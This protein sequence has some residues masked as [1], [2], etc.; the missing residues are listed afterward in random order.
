MEI[1]RGR[2][3]QSH[4][5]LRHLEDVVL[6]TDGLVVELGTTQSAGE[7]RALQNLLLLL[8]PAP[9]VGERVQEEMSKTTPQTSTPMAKENNFI[10]IRVPKA[11][12]LL[13]LVPPLP[14]PS[15]W[16]TTKGLL[17]GR[18]RQKTGKKTGPNPSLDRR[19]PIG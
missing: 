4:S 19:R 7:T 3:E 18:W 11:N 16:S 1:V 10:R 5:L 13:T 15:L 17:L 12:R 6:E 9:Q 2:T 8:L 14:S